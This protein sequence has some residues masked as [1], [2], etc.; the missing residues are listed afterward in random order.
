MAFTH[1]LAVE[2]LATIPAYVT[3]FQGA[4]GPGTIDIDK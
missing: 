3:D 4:F 1:E 2:V